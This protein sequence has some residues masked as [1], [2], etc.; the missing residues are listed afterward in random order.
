MT[1]EERKKRVSKL[2]TE[3]QPY[4]EKAGIPEAT[5]IPKMAYRP[6][7]KMNFMSLSFLVK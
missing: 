4:F 1:P 2:R 6:K 7:G 3:H 5:F